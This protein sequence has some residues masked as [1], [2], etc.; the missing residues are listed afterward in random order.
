MTH[1]ND[2]NLL[3]QENQDYTNQH[4]QQL[5]TRKHDGCGGHQNQSYQQFI[6]HKHNGGVEQVNTKL[7]PDGVLEEKEE[8]FYQWADNY[9]VWNN[10]SYTPTKGNEMVVSHTF[11]G[12]N[13]V[14]NLTKIKH[15][16]K[17]KTRIVS[18]ISTSNKSDIYIRRTSIISMGRLTTIIK[19]FDSGWNY[20]LDLSFKLILLLVIWS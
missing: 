4:D 5:M 10:N 14:F 6:A 15:N 12:H 13:S 2:I 3:S 17:S 18:E 1:T 9:D 16:R 20:I 8:W 11:D 19:P 7:E